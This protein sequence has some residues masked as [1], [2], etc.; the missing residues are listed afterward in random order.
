[1]DKSKSWHKFWYRFFLVCGIYLIITAFYNVFN[2]KS[3]IFSLLIGLLDLYLY[4]VHRTKL[5]ELEDEDSKLPKE[6]D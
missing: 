3:G 2:G 5:K 1:M 6:N 4:N